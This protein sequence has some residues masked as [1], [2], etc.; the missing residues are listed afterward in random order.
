MS[1]NQSYLEFIYYCEDFSTNGVAGQVVVPL[2]RL[3]NDFIIWNGAQLLLPGKI[4]SF[5]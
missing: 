3:P 1:T 4:L 2:S 5:Y